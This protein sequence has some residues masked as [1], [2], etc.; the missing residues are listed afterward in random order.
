MTFGTI[1]LYAAGSVLAVAVYLLLE[2][3]VRLCRGN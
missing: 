2:T 1:A 3:V